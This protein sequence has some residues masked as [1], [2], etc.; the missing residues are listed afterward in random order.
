LHDAQSTWK[1]LLDDILYTQMD[2]IPYSSQEITEGDINAVTNVL[3]SKYLTQGPEVQIFENELKQRFGVSYAVCCSSG[4]AA[5]HLSYAAMGVDNQSIGFVPAVT[6]SA[7]ANAFRYQ[8]AK[9]AFCDINPETGIIDLNS[10]EEQL[11]KFRAKS[12]SRCVISPVSFAGKVAPLLEAKKLA[13]SYNCL[14]FE[15]ASHSAGAYENHGDPST[16][17]ISS[18]H[19]DAAC[20]SFHPVKH[21]CAGEGGAVLT[22]NAKISCRA[23]QLRTHGITR[24]FSNDHPTPW[25]YEQNDLGWNYRMSDIHAA[26]GRSQL[27]RLDGSLESRKKLASNYNNAFSESPFS[28]TFSVP[29]LEDGHSWHLYVIRFIKEGIRDKAH[30]YLMSKGVMTQIHYTPLYKHPYYRR[31]T[32]DLSLPGAEKYFQSCLSI[33]MYPSLTAGQQNRVIDAMESFIKSEM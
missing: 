22:N 13:N 24:P 12:K 31:I 16:S 30:K 23:T 10:L 26:L 32:G 14:L 29:K 2:A 28:E 5:I 7:T 4:T 21:I 33:P 17:S 9:V 25:Y 8:G 15:D 20:L 11:V 27:N 1:L 3:R 18:P 6:F 19:L